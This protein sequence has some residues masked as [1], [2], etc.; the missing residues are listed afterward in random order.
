MIYCGDKWATLFLPAYL[1][2]M[3]VV[4][5]NTK[6]KTWKCDDYRPSKM[7]GSSVISLAFALWWRNCICWC[8]GSIISKWS[9]C[10]KQIFHQLHHD[11]IIY[12]EVNARFLECS[13]K[14]TSKG[15]KGF[16]VV[17]TRSLL[18]HGQFGNTDEFELCQWRSNKPVSS[19]GP[20]DECHWGA[21]S[22]QN[23]MARVA[24]NREVMSSVFQKL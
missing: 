12:V 24:S 20:C 7:N 17:K 22:W 8:I 5:F 2:Y 3:T 21:V 18:V 11:R 9:G 15:A 14:C 10:E 4:F 16:G 1:Q 6:R 13:G 19:C 23:K